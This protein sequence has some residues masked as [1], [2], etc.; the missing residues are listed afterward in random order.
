MVAATTHAPLMAATLA[1]ELSGDYSL[2][3]PLLAATAISA[4]LSRRLRE[5]S[6]YTEELR[7]RGIPWR[8]SLTQRLA[9]AVAARDILTMDPP[10]VDASAS[11][12]E[13]LAKLSEPDVRV[14][15]VPGTPLRALDLNDLKRLWPKERLPNATARRQ[16][17]R[18]LGRVAPG[19]AAPDLA[20]KLWTAPWGELPVV[21]GANGSR[22]SSPAGRS[23]AHSMPKCSAATCCSPA[24]SASKAK[25]KPK[26]SS[27]FPPIAAS[28]RLRSPP[29]CATSPCALPRSAS[30]SA[31]S[32]SRSAGPRI[33]RVEEIPAGVQTG[34]K[35]IGCWCWARRTPSTRCAQPAQQHEPRSATDAAYR[36]LHW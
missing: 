31:W 26:T 14:V 10:Q 34:R 19:F 28:R 30:A 17:P 13:A 1:F 33:A 32:C 5:D 18:S 16:R 7:R 12:E 20:Q 3:I 25:T 2:V 35:A 6:V 23:S 8:G 22:A 21:E 36:S 4:L 11:L 29:R 9:H 24:W 27:S 15:Y